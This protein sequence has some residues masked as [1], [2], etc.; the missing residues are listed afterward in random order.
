[1]PQVDVNAPGCR[2]IKYLIINR[3]VGEKLEQEIYEPPSHSASGGVHA[4][5]TRY[6][7]R[8]FKHCGL[9]YLKFDDV[10]KALMR[11]RS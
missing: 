8:S 2:T 11:Y 7:C 3:T 5:K 6:A 4:E 9:H 10:V 1:M